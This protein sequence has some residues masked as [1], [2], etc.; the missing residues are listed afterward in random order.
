MT[1][2]H[3]DFASTVQHAV[4]SASDGVAHGAP[5]LLIASLRWL[6]SLGLPWEAAVAALALACALAAFLTIWLLLRA[7]GSLGSALGR[8]VGATSAKVRRL[9]ASF[10]HRKPG[11]PRLRS[12]EAEPAS[13]VPRGYE[14][15]PGW[16]PPV[17]AVAFPAAVFTSGDLAVRSTIP[18]ATSRPTPA[19]VAPAASGTSSRPSGSFGADEVPPGFLYV[20]TR[21][22]EIAPAQRPAAAGQASAP[23]RTAEAAPEPH[24]AGGETAAVSELEEARRRRARALAGSTAVDETLPRDEA[25]RSSRRR[26]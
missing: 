15:A 18:A 26:R 4:A 9:T 7:A 20:D 1:R 5:K 23:A 13:H 17:S 8:G 12:R 16:G 6:Q 11:R 3:G 25:G 10:A 14:L 2:Q 22:P 19:S 24:A 21:P